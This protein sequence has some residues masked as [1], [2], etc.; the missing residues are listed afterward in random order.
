MNKAPDGK[1]LAA[2]LGATCIGGAN[3]NAVSLSNLELPPLF[4]AALRFAVAAALFLLLLRMQRIPLARGRDAAGA[5]I[6]GLLGIGVTYALFYYALTELSVGVASVVG[7]T[8]PLFTLGIAIAA[9]QERLTARGVIGGILVVAGIAVL[10]RDALAGGIGG[11]HLLAAVLA[12]MAV[13]TSSVVA[14][15]LPGVHPL[16]LNAIGVAAGALL[17]AAGSLFLRED[18]ALPRESRTIAAV[19]W[20]AVIGS[21]GLYQF[22]LYVIKRWSAS[23]TVYIIAA[24]PL[25]AVALGTV[26]LDQPVTPEV[27]IGGALVV[28]A[29]Y[30]GTMPGKNR[31]DC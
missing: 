21:I 30:V 25:V 26:L 13:S 20:L 16:N 22:Y 12:T 9:G 23:A 14:K 8:A 18:W 11:T 31:Q 7:A 4:G 27:L 19:A 29:V 24:M 1:T 3:Y 5:A 6:Y 15:S 17:L 10:S 2:F 28:V